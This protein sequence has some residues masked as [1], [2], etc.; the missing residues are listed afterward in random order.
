MFETIKLSFRAGINADET[1]LK[2]EGWYVSANGV[3]FWQ[4]GWEVMGGWEPLTPTPFTG[5]CRGACQWNSPD[6]EPQLLLGTQATLEAFDGTNLRVV[7]PALTHTRLPSGAFSQG[8][9]GFTVVNHPAHGMRAGDVVTIANA[10]GT[11]KNGN[12]TVVAVIDPN[13]YTFAGNLSGGSGGSIAEAYSPLPSGPLDASSGAFPRT[14]SIDRFGEMV[15]A[16]P[17]GGKLFAGF[18][19]NGAPASLIEN[20]NFAS[21]L[22]GWAA[23]TGWSSSGGEA[24]HTG[25]TP[26][27]LSQNIRDAK[28]GHVFLLAFGGRSVTSLCN[29][30]VSINAG[31]TPGLI[32]IIPSFQPPVAGTLTPYTLMF[33]MPAFPI[34]LVF[35]RLDTN[36]SRELH[37]DDV[38]LTEVEISPVDQAPTY[39]NAVFVDPHS[40]VVALGTVE[41]DG[42]FNPMCVR[43]SAIGD[44]RVWV[45]DTDN[46]ASEMI[47]SGGG[48]LMAGCRTRDQNVIWSDTATFVQQWIGNVGEAFAYRQVSDRIGLYSRFA[49]AE[50]DGLV[51]F[52]GSDEDFKMFDGARVVPLDCPIRKD[53]FDNLNKAQKSKISSYYYGAKSEWHICYPRGESTEN[54]HKIVYNLAEKHWTHHEMARTTGLDTGPFGYPLEF[55]TNGKIYKHECGTLADGEYRTWHLTTGFSDIRDGSRLMAINRHWMDI[56]DQIGMFQITHRLRDTARGD[57]IDHGPQIVDTDTQELF[58]MAM[59]R[60]WQIHYQNH[61]DSEYLRMGVE[62]VDAK[63][64]GARR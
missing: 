56:K 12:R 52:I 48:Y 9:V 4:N 28:E 40:V 46:V 21:G 58:L 37:L 13:H 20:G 33:V 59:G 2:A 19:S 39:S 61:D 64:T 5:V 55:A 10:T 18:I 45:P 24:F 6:N 30:S 60:Q 42:D 22:T 34:D 27:N 32:E 62:S 15:I 25:T 31:A 49:S 1:P 51:L 14:W 23:G 26:S 47:L 43:N 41:A 17:N 16:S 63:E 3:R 11:G 44:I 36:G 8:P 53:F 35:S 54:S 57:V 7:T 29:M 38:T 50:A